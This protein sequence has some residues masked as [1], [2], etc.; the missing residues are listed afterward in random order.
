[1]G[2]DC[3]IGAPRRAHS[4]SLVARLPLQHA[5]ATSLMVIAFVFAAATASAAAEELRFQLS[6]YGTLAFG[7][8]PQTSAD[9][10]L[11]AYLTPKDAAIAALPPL[12]EGG[13]FALIASVTATSLVCYADTIFRDDFDADGG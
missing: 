11:K 13:G 1:M 6:G 7:R 4:G 5:I 2:N 3:S 10:Q 8:P 12:Q 9:M